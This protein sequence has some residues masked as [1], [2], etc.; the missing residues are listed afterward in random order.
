MAGK[1][2]SRT[3]LKLLG[4]VF[5]ISKGLVVVKAYTVP[6]LTAKVY[7]GKGREVG[8]VSN[9]FGPVASPLVALKP[10]SDKEFS[11]GDALYIEKS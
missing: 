4:E 3:K 11:E 2:A 6:K 9:I 5:R 10:V 1:S 8:Y 7:D